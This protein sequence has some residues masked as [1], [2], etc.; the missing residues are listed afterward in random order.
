[1]AEEIKDPPR[2][3]YS[4]N[5]NLGEIAKFVEDHAKTLHQSGWSREADDLYKWVR[6][7]RKSYERKV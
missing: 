1:M 2:K 4:A 5:P 7:L 6:E 3:S